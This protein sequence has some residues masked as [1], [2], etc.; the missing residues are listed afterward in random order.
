MS[1]PLVLFD[2]MVGGASRIYGR[3]AS[4]GDHA[5]YLAPDAFVSCRVTPDWVSMIHNCP[6]PLR[7]DVK[8]RWRPSAAHEGLSF[9]PASV[10]SLEL[11]SRRFTVMIWKRPDTLD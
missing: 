4:R 10:R 6:E 1:R 11:L 3:Y 9:S 5:P 8:T 2:G 7:D